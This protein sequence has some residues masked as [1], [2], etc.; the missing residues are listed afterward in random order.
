MITRTY[1]ELEESTFNYK[2]IDVRSPSEFALSTIPNAINI[3]IFTDEERALI[4]TLYKQEGKNIAVKKGLEIIG[5]KLL[6]LYIEFE[7]AAINQTKLVVFCAR[8][9]MRSSTIVQV[10]SEFS[11]PIMKLEGGYK[12][13]RN[14]IVTKLPILLN[15]FNYISLSGK[16][17]TGKTNVLHELKTLGYDVLDLEEC[18]NHYGSLLGGVMHSAQPS[19]KMF[20]SLVYDS[21]KNCT[22]ST[23]FIESESRRIGKIM[24]NEALY[25]KVLT[26]TKVEITA[27]IERRIEIIRKQYVNNNDQELINTLELLKKY[28]AESTI[29]YY[30]NLI[31]E[32]NHDEVIE[33]LINDYYDRVYKNSGK[34]AKYSIENISDHKTALELI[35]L[36]E[37]DQKK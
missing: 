22:S 7:K 8:G 26:A 17:G 29:N 30:Q 16:T 21:L 20:E 37:I 11:L 36:F 35:T 25:Q 9:G 24:M 13:Y 18:A 6:Q 27:T 19:Q 31:R 4:G 23:V 2:F 14:H 33:Y 32:N 12:A 3:P 1:E 28:V 34:D 5:P 10:F 15:Q